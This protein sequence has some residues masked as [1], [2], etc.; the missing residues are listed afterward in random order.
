MSTPPRN[1]SESTTT[2]RLTAARRLRKL[3]NDRAYNRRRRDK[4]LTDYYGRK[5]RG[6][7]SKLG[8]I[9]IEV[10]SYNP[11]NHQVRLRCIKDQRHFPITMDTDKFWKLL[12]SGNLREA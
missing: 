9:T 12:R 1:S 4:V 2:S 11:D 5:Y 3:F 8:F 10:M 7:D 6:H